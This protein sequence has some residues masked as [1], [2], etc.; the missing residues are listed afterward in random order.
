VHAS[1]YLQN[2]LAWA[3]VGTMT[4]DVREKII[5]AAMTAYA[6]SGF[7]GA[8]TRRVAEI[9]GVNEVTIFRNFGSKAALMDEAL[10]RRVASLKMVEPPLPVRPLDPFGELTVWCETF[11]TQLRGSRELL[12]KAMGAAE[13]RF[14]ELA[15]GFEPARCADHEL[16]RYI[17]ALVREGWIGTELMSDPDRTELLTAAQTLLI[18]AL[19]GDAMARELHDDPALWVSETRAARRYV[20]MFFRALGVAPEAHAG[21]ALADSASSTHTTSHT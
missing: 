6:E 5:T 13:E 4:N 9:A 17:H 1:T 15:N 16:N 7:Q 2:R 19:W 21:S 12:R 20:Q 3:Y 8:T 10:F 14:H 11:L 18:G